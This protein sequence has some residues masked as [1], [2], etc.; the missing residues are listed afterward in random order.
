M[1]TELQN[2]IDISRHY[3]DDPAYVIA[4]GGNTSFK[5]EERIWIKASGIP[6]AGIEESGF[7]CLSRELLGKI[8]VNSYSEDPVQREEEVKAHMRRRLLSP[9]IIFVPRWRPPCIT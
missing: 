8:E 2:L 4:G 7:V 6:L 1:T 3:G 5:N 9:P